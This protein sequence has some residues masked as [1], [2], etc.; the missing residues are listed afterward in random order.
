[1]ANWWNLQKLSILRIDFALSPLSRS[2]P[3]GE[4]SCLWISSFVTRLFRQSVSDVP[5]SKW[6]HF[7]NCVPPPAR[8]P[9]SRIP[10][11]TKIRRQLIFQSIKESSSKYKKRPPHE[12]G[13]HLPEFRCPDS[14]SMTSHEDSW[15]FKVSKNRISENCELI[16]DNWTQKSRPLWLVDGF[17]GTKINPHLRIHLVVRISDLTCQSAAEIPTFGCVISWS[18]YVA[19][20]AGPKIFFLVC[21][22]FILL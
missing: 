9:M 4:P 1:M 7:M 12:F 14:R 13:G 20:G 2:S 5:I 16:T 6:R 8:V 21:W 19:G 22:E 15:F 10:N 17:L 3:G 18:R 11:D